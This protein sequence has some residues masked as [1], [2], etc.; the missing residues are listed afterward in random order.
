MV[1]ISDKDRELLGKLDCDKDF[2]ESLD[3]QTCERF[4]ITHSD[5]CFWPMKAGFLEARLRGLLAAIRAH[6]ETE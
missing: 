4:A 5:P 2:Y 6:E 3:T 1:K